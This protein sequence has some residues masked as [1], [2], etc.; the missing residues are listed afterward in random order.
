MGAKLDNH[1]KEFEKA[2]LI[3]IRNKVEEPMLNYL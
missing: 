2:Q 3:T 1:K